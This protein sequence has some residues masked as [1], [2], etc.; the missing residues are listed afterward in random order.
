MKKALVVD[1][2][3]YNLTLLSAIIRKK[4]VEV[5]KAKN[6]EEA[7]KQFTDHSPEIVFLDFLLPKKD[8]TEILIEMK[9]MNPDVIGVMVTALSSADIVAKAKDAGASGFITKPYDV[10]KIYSTLKKFNIIAENL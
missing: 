1:D 9:K 7:M 8:G 6:S 2:T 4:G 5:F 3:D 10:E